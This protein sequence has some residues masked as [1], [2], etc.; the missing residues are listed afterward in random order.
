[1]KECIMSFS[2]PPSPIKFYDGVTS[3]KQLHTY[4]TSNEWLKEVSNSAYKVAF[5]E[6]DEK[7]SLQAGSKTYCHT[8]PAG[9]FSIAREDR[10]LFLSESLSSISTIS[11]GEAFGEETTLFAD[12]EAR[13]D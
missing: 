9:V 1:M 8:S 12:N 4:I 3:V 10:L 11:A 7:H 13:P 5:F 6:S 2:T